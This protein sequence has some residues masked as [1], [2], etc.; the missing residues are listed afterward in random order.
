VLYR[1][2]VRL[3][4]IVDDKKRSAVRRIFPAFNARLKEDHSNGRSNVLTNGDTRGEG[5]LH[6]Q[7]GLTDQSSLI[8]D[9]SELEQVAATP[10]TKLL[11]EL[12]TQYIL[13]VSALV[14]DAVVL[15]PLQLSRS[16]GPDRSKL[17]SRPLRRLAASKPLFHIWALQLLSNIPRHDSPLA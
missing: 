9:P 5:L 3:S 10:F 1:K 14:N 16:P 12:S 2:R 8:M 11:V 4:A 6:A 7:I 15:A 17:A 13:I